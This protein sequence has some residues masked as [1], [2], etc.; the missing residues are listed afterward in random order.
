MSKEEYYQSYV[1]RYIV[2]N[3]TKSSVNTNYLRLA[4]D[5]MVTYDGYYMRKGDPFEEEIR[6]ALEAIYVMLLFYG[7]FIS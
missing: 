6:G 5:L 4:P 7:C 3:K 1:R 2:Y